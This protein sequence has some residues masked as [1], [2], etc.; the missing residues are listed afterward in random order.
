MNDEILI[1]LGRVEGK[2]DTIG[3]TL[4]SHLARIERLED[5]QTATENVVSGLVA[6]SNSNVNWITQ[7]LTAFGVLV[8]L[9]AALYERLP[10]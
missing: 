3:S 7:L 1:A 8:A 10:I 2:V 5:R 4:G 6:K 9:G